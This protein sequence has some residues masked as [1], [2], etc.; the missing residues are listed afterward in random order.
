MANFSLLQIILKIKHQSTRKK[1]ASPPPYFSKELLIIQTL[2]S[3]PG[4]THQGVTGY[5]AEEIWQQQ[6]AVF[7]ESPLT[8]DQVTF[9]LQYGAKTG[10]YLLGGCSSNAV[11]PQVCNPT[12]TDTNGTSYQTYYINPSMASYNPRN[13]AYVA[14]GYVFDPTV[15]ALGY[16]PCGFCGGGGPGSNP[17]AG[18]GSS[19][20][21]TAGYG[22]A[23]SSTL[24]VPQTSVACGTC[25]Q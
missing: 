13:G 1:M 8:L 22:S 17:Y 20:Y 4:N 24:P 3:L 25:R 11:T 2:R 15:P 10:I 14:V 9:L 18:A 21:L 16:L 5:T 23:H 6:N 7:P 19:Q 12:L